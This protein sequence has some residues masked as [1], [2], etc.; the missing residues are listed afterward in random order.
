M[1]NMQLQS[2]AAIYKEL[3]ARMSKAEKMFAEKGELMMPF[4]QEYMRILDAMTFIRGMSQLVIVAPLT[5]NPDKYSQ[6]RECMRALVVGYF[7]KECPERLSQVEGLIDENLLSLK[8]TNI[9]SYKKAA[10][11]VAN[12]VAN[13]VKE[14]LKP[15]K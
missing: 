14:F 10:L 4:F 6:H 5:M 11:L 15:K 1:E 3:Q 9:S 12:I 13:I 2:P 8:P 7:S